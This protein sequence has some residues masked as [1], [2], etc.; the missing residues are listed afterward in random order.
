[1]RSDTVESSF[2]FFYLFEVNYHKFII[3]V[4]LL[5]IIKLYFNC[6]FGIIILYVYFI[7]L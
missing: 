6:F 5:F 1:M 3:T 2:I 7:K 4:N